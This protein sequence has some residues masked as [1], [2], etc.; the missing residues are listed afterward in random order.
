MK[1]TR[2]GKA[3]S[4]AAMTVLAATLALSGPAACTPARGL[5]EGASP[6]L[7]RFLETYFLSWSAGDMVTYRSLFHDTASIVALAGGRV[8]Y[9]LGPDEF[10]SMQARSQEAHPMTERMTA[11]EALEDSVAA[12][13][14]VE[15]RL[16]GEGEDIRGVDLFTLMREPSG[17]W[18]IASLLFYQTE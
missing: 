6:G 17:S 13:A 16:T 18:K 10:V 2:R 12:T 1:I 11:R 9:A 8:V 7:E 4:R 15:W 14:R 5:S 3:R